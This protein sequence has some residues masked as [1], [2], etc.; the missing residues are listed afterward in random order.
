M[1]SSIQSGSA[2]N[3]IYGSNNRRGGQLAGPAR[4]FSL[5]VKFFNEK[6]TFNDV[7]SCFFIKKFCWD[8]QIFLNYS[9]LI[10]KQHYIT[11]LFIYFFYFFFIFFTINPHQSQSQILTGTISLSGP[12]SQA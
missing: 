2:R 4:P 6:S 10:V 5:K 1:Q 3:Y 9:G 7:R 8:R 12:P 11:L